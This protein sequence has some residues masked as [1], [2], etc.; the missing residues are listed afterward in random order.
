MHISQPTDAQKQTAWQ[1]LR[2]LP[3]E[4]LG[5]AAK[6]LIYLTTAGVT[7]YCLLPGNPAGVA[8]PAVLLPLIEAIGP[9]L[10]ASVVEKVASGKEKSS[11]EI[12]AIL[13]EATANSRLNGQKLASLPSKRE[14]YQGISLLAEQA[15]QNQAALVGL[16][17]ETHTM[18]R[19]LLAIQPAHLGLFVDVPT[20]P[21]Y[22]VG[23]DDL[24]TDLVGPLTSGE[25]LALSAEGLPGVG[26]TTLAVALAHHPNVLAH[27]SDGVLWAGLGQ[28]PDVLGV[29]AIWAEALGGDVTELAEERAR[30]VAVKRL[31]GQRRLLLV[32][33][34][35]WDSEAAS[36]LR[37]GG[38]NC[39]HLLTTRNKAIATKFAGSPRSL[40]VPTLAKDPAFALLQALAPQVCQAHPEET[41]QLTALVGGLPLALELLGGFLAAP[42]RG[43][44]P[45]L[46]QKALAKMADPLERLA[47]AAVRLGSV[48]STAQTLRET[49]ALSLSALQEE[50]GAEA[51]QAFYALGAF[52][53]KP[54]AFSWQ[55]ATAVAACAEETIAWLVERNLVEAEADDLLLHQT[56]AEVAQEELPP[57]ATERHRAYYL[58][59]VNADREEWR[60]IEAVYEQIKHAWQQLPEDE[61]VLD[62]VWALGLYQERRGLW[63]DKTAWTN[64]GLEVAETEE[65]KEAEASMLVN[66]GYVYNSL[67]QREEA[68]AYYNRALPI[69]EEVG[70]RAGLATTLNNIGSVYNDL[71]QREEALAYYNRALPIREE[72]GDRAGLAAT[73][74]NIGGVYNDLGQRE[75]ALAYYNRALPI[76]EE[77]GDRAG[78]AA[79]LNNI[80]GVYNSLG[81][82]EEAL[83]YY[84]RALPITEE[85]GDRARLATTL[86]NIGYVYDSLGQREEALSYYN[87]ALPIR[88]EVGD[89]AGLATTLNNIGYVYDSL[90]QREEA[91]SYYNRAL[92]IREEVGDRYGESITRYNIA[93]IYRAENQLQKAVNELR[94][95]VELDRQVQHP[96]LEDD[97]AML[98][99]VEAEL[100]D[101]QS[102][103][104]S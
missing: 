12:V 49:I 85:V 63:R 71:G 9:D 79:T 55:A 75:E 100:A 11:D 68:L 50:G 10:L 7:A 65:Q 53:P 4:L 6:G 103:N 52:A 86:N 97:L 20:L 46:R 89:R 58:D 21:N 23:R 78:L 3:P 25:S 37:C 38:P 5:G 98:A 14:L 26:K 22:F 64:R 41:R 47:L 57:E 82:R 104:P 15:A 43:L 102:G 94:K 87:R 29:L 60:Q 92:P 51:V 62:W 18:L 74:N 95:V 31:I 76:R 73:L 33:D 77:V 93:M 19:Q 1:R 27:F 17:A 39:V 2:A 13:Q 83:A 56:L 96:D 67:G 32:L 8:I 42:R 70:N 90:G 34:D 40:T 91:L 72:V 30:Y 66:L 59:L 61:T 54:A 24:L 28:D 48:A 81:Q 16:H 69:M 44:T 36:W 45:G 35:A 80:G 88:E 84:N 99:Q 101:Q